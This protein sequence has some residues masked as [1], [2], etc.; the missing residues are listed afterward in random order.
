AGDNMPSLRV[1][2]GSREPGWWVLGSLAAT[3]G[4]SSIR[5]NLMPEDEDLSARARKAGVLMH[6]HAFEGTVKLLDVAEMVRRTLPLWTERIG[7]AAVQALHIRA[8]RDGFSFLLNGEEVLL[9]G[10]AATLA[11][12]GLEP[13]QEDEAV[14]SPPGIAPLPLFWYGYNYV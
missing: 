4:A 13:G 14:A 12:F 9:E 6:A 2:A 3:Y 5:A 1:Y 7:A 8:D 11:F 10:P